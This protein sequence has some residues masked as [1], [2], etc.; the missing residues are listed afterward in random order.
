[1]VKIKLSE[2]KEMQTIDLEYKRGMDESYDEYRIRLFENRTTYDISFDDIAELLNFE[3]GQTFGESAYRKEYASFNRGRIYERGINPSDE[4]NCKIRELQKEKI[5][6]QTEKLEYN[7]WLRE[8]AREELFV[9]QIISAIKDNTKPEPKVEKIEIKHGT[10]FG[11]FSFAD[12]HFGKEYKIFGLKDDIINE[13][14]PEIFYERMNVL[15]TEILNRVKIEG[16]SFIKV[17]SLGDVLDGFLRHEQLWT[18]RYGVVDSAK[19]YGKFIGKWLYNLSKEVPIEYHQTSGN[20]CE[21]RL[22]DGKKNSHVN[23]NIEKIILDYIEIIN[24]KNPNLTIVDNKS[25][26]IFTEIAGYNILGIHGEVKDL[27][28]AIKDFSDLYDTRIDYIVSGHKHH[29]TW[30]NCGY[31][32]GVVGVGSIVGTDDFS[33]KIKKSADASASFIIFEEGKGRVQ[34]NMIILN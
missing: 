32:K 17:F 25:G 18:L 1:M 19:I 2:L 33:M 23:D 3:T 24:E 29:S 4:L 30:I 10:K 26:Y 12:C 21:L 22:L 13:Y 16:F 9:E 7:R 34:E 8:E 20:H 28:Q 27:P 31:R 14:S 11:L 6:I 5:K 15:Y